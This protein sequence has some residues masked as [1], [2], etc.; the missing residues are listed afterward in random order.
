M[1]LLIL[2]TVA[3]FALV[4]SAR[5]ELILHWKLDDAS[6]NTA[7][8][9]SGNGLAGTWM[10][11]AGTPSWQST[12]GIDG[13]AF[14]FTG[15][16]AD[17]FIVPTTAVSG[18]PFTMS[19]WVKTTST[20]NDGVVYFGNGSSGTQYYV[21]RVASSSARLGARNTTETLIA[22]TTVNNDEWHHIAGVVEGTALRELYVD[23]APVG[24]GTVDVP[25]LTLNRFGIGALT[26]NTPYSP[27]DLYT[28]WMDDVQLYDTILGPEDIAW[29][30]DNPGSAIIP[31]P[32][33]LLLLLL[34]AAGLFA[35]AR[36]RRR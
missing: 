21:L 11:T 35:S 15:A 2:A 5:G 26:R 3:S 14:Q 13:G 9:S 20:Q 23:G 33:S 17:S 29:L 12:G 22:G 1:R 28:G 19:A 4:Q 16:N 10:G 30:H 8:D 36:R 24:T 32:S 18:T 31:E 25:A 27:A 34:G 6:G 7:A